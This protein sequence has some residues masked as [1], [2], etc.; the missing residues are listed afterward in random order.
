MQEGSKCGEN[1]KRDGYGSPENWCRFSSFFLLKEG[2]L[3]RSLVVLRFAFRM[4]QSWSM[5]REI[6]RT[7]G[8]AGGSKTS[9][10]TTLGVGVGHSRHCQAGWIIAPLSRT[11]GGGGS[12]GR[13]SVEGEA[14]SVATSTI[15]VRTEE[16]TV[17]SAVERGTRPLMWE[18][19]VD[20]A[21]DS[22]PDRRSLRDKVSSGLCLEDSPWLWVEVSEA[23]AP[24]QKTGRGPDWLVV[25]DVVVAYEK[26]QKRVETS[27]FRMTVDVRSSLS[28]GG[29]EHRKNRHLLRSPWNFPW[30]HQG[31]NVLGIRPSIIFAELTCIGRSQCGSMESRSPT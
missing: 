27:S 17:G 20:S 28:C 26:R 19:G 5:V 21:T 16:G 25:P 18:S 8:G 24:G 2:G 1:E 14:S 12:I 4:V 11:L 9:I 13:R 30:E 22:R 31:K 7:C 3:K 23:R 10:R 15:A 6:K 29:R